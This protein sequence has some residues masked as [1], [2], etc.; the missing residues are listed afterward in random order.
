MFLIIKNEWRQLARSKTLQ[1]LLVI[2]AALSAFIIYSNV[3]AF[4]QGKI[5]REQAALQMRNEFLAQDE[6]NPHNAAHFGCY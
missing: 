6:T 4:K 2:I 1:V 3:P 5:Q